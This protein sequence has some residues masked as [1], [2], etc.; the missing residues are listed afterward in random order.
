MSNTIVALL[1]ALAMLAGIGINT[2]LVVTGA[3]SGICSME[4][5]PLPRRK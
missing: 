1:V 2:M 3:V 4:E 5:P